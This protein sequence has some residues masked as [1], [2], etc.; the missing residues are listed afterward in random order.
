MADYSLNQLA[1]STPE[2][3]VKNSIL[4]NS[5]SIDIV[6]KNQRDRDASE[7]G[8]K[9]TAIIDDAAQHNWAIGVADNALRDSI[10]EDS[11]E[12]GKPIEMDD[13]LADSILVTNGLGTEDF[14]AIRG[15]KTQAELDLRL[16]WAKS[17]AETSDR[18]NKTIGEAGRITAMGLGIVSSPEML[19]GVGV[20]AMYK[21]SAS[22]AR[23]AAMEGG[24]AAF[25]AASRLTL[26][27]KYTLEDAFIDT[28]LGAFVGAGVTKGLRMFGKQNP[29]AQ[30]VITANDIATD[31]ANNIGKKPKTGLHTDNVF[32]KQEADSKLYA[33]NLKTK[34][35][36]DAEFTD[37]LGKADT[38]VKNSTAKLSKAIEKL[39]KLEANPTATK[40]ELNAARAALVKA[41]KSL[42]KANAKIDELNSLKKANDEKFNID[43]RLKSKKELDAEVSIA[44]IADD[45]E[46]T[47]TELKDY[48]DS[49]DFTMGDR[50]DLQNEL[51]NIKKSI[52]D[53]ADEVAGVM[54]GT[55][56]A[57]DTKIY[58]GMSKKGKLALAGLALVST[59]SLSAS[60]GEEDGLGLGAIMI[61]GAIGFV[62]FKG[63]RHMDYN[64]IKNANVRSMMKKLYG[65]LEKGVRTQEF[66]TNNNMSRVNKATAA[67]ADTAYTGL[68]STVAPFI[69]EGGAAADFAKKILFSK[70][71]GMGAME[72]KIDWFNSAISKYNVEED[73]LIKK[74]KAEPDSGAKTGFFS[75][76][77]GDVFRQKVANHIDGLEESM[78]PAVKEMADNVRAHFKDM[79][80]K[81]KEYETFG[82]EKINF[83][84]NYIPRLWK[85]EKLSAM[86][87]KLSKDD[88][89]K[90]RQGLINVLSKKSGDISKATKEADIYMDSWSAGYA[91]ASDANKADVVNMLDKKGMFADDLERDEILDAITGNTDKNARAKYRIDFDI[92]DFKEEMESISVDL[93][94]SDTSLTV[95]MFM[96]RNIKS[97]IDKT[98]NQLYSSASLSYKG[99]T[100]VVK[101]NAAVAAITDRAL[102]KKA[103]DIASIAQG[104]PLTPDDVFL[105]NASNMLKDITL[106]GKLTHVLLSTP[107]EILQTSFNSGFSNGIR[108]LYSSIAQKFGKDSELLNQLANINALGTNIKR[109]DMSFHGYSD[110]L[111]D[112]TDSEISS[113]FRTGSMKF[114]DAII[115]MSGLGGMTD[116]LQVANRVTNATQF[117]KMLHGSKNTLTNSTRLISF[118]IDDEALKMFSKDMFEFT[119]S[120]ELKKMNMEMWSQ[121]QKDKFSDILFNMNQQYSPDTTAG[122]TPLFSRTS[123]LG[124]MISTLG[125]YSMHQFNTHGLSGLKHMDKPAMAQLAA[126]IGGSYLGLQAR[127]A[128]QGK[129]VEDEVIWQYAIM[130]APQLLGLGAVKSMV[131]PAVVKNNEAIAATI[132]FQL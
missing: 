121:K 14:K 118:G 73:A 104:K 76:D 115:Y 36:H 54:N 128:V 7:F 97:I 85:H 94:G 132:G 78:S 39:S 89:L 50:L 113:R 21:A 1:F 38:Y 15:S 34:A 13:E 3:H 18:V 70:D 106:G 9:Y 24:G 20:G 42:N 83:D 117:A 92:K 46:E 108:G 107:V 87:K 31:K 52:P 93:D 8:E 29:T 127:F 61:I 45:L 62:A 49:D 35:G 82:F 72:R 40:A 41:E 67:I 22:I 25:V 19:V 124:R 80:D 123:S 16:A 23:I 96:D 99:Y 79:L 37:K 81:N 101:M 90:V 56:K 75:G 57:E 65:K 30:D 47:T 69:K 43:N 120:G 109:L 28:T 102:R 58:K 111:L 32:F 60:N 116:I 51:D 63:A 27:E 44:K 48:I 86:I 125:G 126:G 129:E 6:N 10:V 4:D 33:D 71:Y 77:N 84:D 112:L 98:G 131:S 122:E 114:R 55:I 88:V 95:D 11:N 59:S 5:K 105:H 26:D 12:G 64:K 130:S 17:D 103:E 119:S 2:P 74:W 66:E 53:E 68:L 91:S 100:S 110:D